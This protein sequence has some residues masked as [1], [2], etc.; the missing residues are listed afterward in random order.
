MPLPKKGREDARLMFIEP[1]SIMQV[2]YGNYLM[3]TQQ[4]NDMGTFMVPIIQMRKLRFS[5]EGNLPYI[6]QEL[7]ANI[8]TQSLLI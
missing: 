1:C 6:S 2:H 4:P 3:Y 5:Q 7:S 8:Q